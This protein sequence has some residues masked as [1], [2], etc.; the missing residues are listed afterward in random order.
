ML[1]VTSLNLLLGLLLITLGLVL[2]AADHF[3]CTWQDQGTLSPSKY[4][5]TL[6]CDAPVTR[7]N[8]THAKYICTSSIFFGLGHTSIR[9]ADW[10]FL[11]PNVLEFANPCG[12]KGYADCEWR[13]WGLCNGTADAK[14]DMSNVLCRYMGHHDDCSWPV[15]PAHAPDRVQ[16]WNQV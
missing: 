5:Y 2:T 10:G 16:I 12:R 6:Y 4:G 11:G 9:V 7:I 15:N 14:A 1:G 13:Y 3:T 8:D